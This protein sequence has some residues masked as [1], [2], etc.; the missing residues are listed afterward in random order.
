MKRQITFKHKNLLLAGDLYLPEGFDESKPYPAIVITHPAGGVKEQTTGLYASKLAD[1]GYLALAF[2]AS[3]QGASEGQPRYIEEPALRVEDVRCA[4][5]YFTTLPFVDKKRIGAM[6]VCA[7]AAYS[8]NAAQTDHRIKAVVGISTTDIGTFFRVGIDNSVKLPQQLSTLEVV[9]GERTA[10]ANGAAPAYA[11]YVPASAEGL[12]DNDLIEAH[13]YYYKEHP[14]PN[15][16]N[17][18]LLSGFD[19]IMAFTACDQV[20]TYLTQPLLLVAGSKAGTKWL[21]D[22]IYAKATGKK[23]LYIVNGATHMSLYGKPEHVDE[24][25]KKAKAFFDENL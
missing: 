10:I 7:G 25:A 2:D 20:D 23:E 11:N 12:T 24:A 18:M 14:H 9:A 4:V 17:K 8:I 22:D 6:G 16:H 13:N 15:S 5:D 19:K 1:A 21:S 3:H